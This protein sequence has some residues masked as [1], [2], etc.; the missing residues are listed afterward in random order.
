MKIVG[1]MSEYE[2]EYVTTKDLFNG[3]SNI[4]SIYD[5]NLKR[6]YRG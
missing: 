3:L 6:A 2:N 4:G 5:M 1:V